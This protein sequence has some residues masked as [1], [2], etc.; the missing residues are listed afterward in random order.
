MRAVPGDVLILSHPNYGVLAG[1]AP[2]A[3]AGAVIDVLRTRARRPRRL[4]AASIADAVHTQRFAV[5]V[6]DPPEDYRALPRD[7]G[8]YYERIP[9]PAIRW[10]TGSRPT[11]RM[12]AKRTTSRISAKALSGRR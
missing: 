11:M 5:I 1:K 10:P 2:H 12:D 9:A 3:Q 8:R 4:L 6:V 7:L